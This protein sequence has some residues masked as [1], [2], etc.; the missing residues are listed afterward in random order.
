[1]YSS[2]DEAALSNGILRI[3]LPE[4][5]PKKLAIQTPKG[6]WFILQ[7]AEE[8]IEIMPQARFESVNIM[9]FKID[10]L[11]GTT[12]RE[13]RR[14]TE[15]V[16]KYPGNYLVYFADNLETEPENTFCL[17]QTIRFKNNTNN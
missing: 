7:E 15:L 1:M 10:K 4:E 3:F 11:I 16:F 8:A 6:E 2:V 17:Q 9:E 5:V 12:W 13:S 14:V